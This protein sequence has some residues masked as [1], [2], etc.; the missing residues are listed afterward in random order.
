MPEADPE[1]LTISR[2]L[3]SNRPFKRYFPIPDK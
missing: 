3:L 2:E 1:L